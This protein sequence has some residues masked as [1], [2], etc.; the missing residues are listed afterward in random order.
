MAVVLI[1]TM[2]TNAI[3]EGLN[4]RRNEKDTADKAFEASQEDKGVKVV[5]TVEVEDDETTSVSTIAAGK[6]AGKVLR[7]RRGDKKE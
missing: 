2:I 7:P 1:V 3:E 4:D 5:N 6:A